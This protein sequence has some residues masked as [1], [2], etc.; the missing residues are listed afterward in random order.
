MTSKQL[1]AVKV[2]R[3]LLKKTKYNNAMSKGK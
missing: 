1:H 3:K 2:L